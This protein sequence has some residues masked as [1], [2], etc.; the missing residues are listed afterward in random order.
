MC[1]R[2]LRRTGEKQLSKRENMIIMKFG[3]TSVQNG[4]AISRVVGIVGS[5]LQEKPVV[6]VSALSKVTRS[7]VRIA[8]DAENGNSDSVRSQM[9]AL[10]MRHH[11]VCEGLLSGEILDRTLA[12][13]DEICGD[14]AAFVDGVCR[15]CELSPRSRARIVSTGEI[16]SS[17]IVSAAMNL[18]GIR[19]RWVDARRLIITDGDYMNAR[20]DLELSESNICRIISREAKGADMILTQG[21]I[22]STSEGAPSVLGF[23]GSDYSAAILG[24]A[25]DADRIEIWTDVDGIRTSDPRV[26]GST[27]R[28]GRVSYEEAGLMARLGARVLHP[29]TMEPASR[30]NIPIKV[31][32][33]LNPQGEGSVVAIEDGLSLGPKSVAFLREI[34]F[35]EICSGSGS[36]TVG[37]LEDIFSVLRKNNLEI[38]LLTHSVGKVSMTLESGQ[39]GLS[40]A[41]RELSSRYVLTHYRDK[42]QVS[43]V[44]RHP[45]T[46][47]GLHDGIRSCGKVYMMSQGSSMM[48][49]SAVVDRNEVDG[50]VNE[51]HKII[52]NA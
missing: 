21:F 12:R 19:C 22:S 40:A 24:M 36:D 35:L 15:I 7:L 32:N 50:F 8:E 49:V 38:S 48:D 26:V 16:L 33:T 34:E 13:V 17:V 43:V 30:K 44:G 2:V 42:S 25:L 46:H 51:L 23:E 11:D 45:E 3:G 9:E 18:N 47:K 29:K 14:L 28:I 10:V 39:D 6:V 31:L 41:T 5:R 4:E 1:R 20:P 37:M 52:F 27:C